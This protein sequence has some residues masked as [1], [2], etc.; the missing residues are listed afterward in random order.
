PIVLPTEFV[1]KYSR[2]DALEIR[3]AKGGGR[4][5]GHLGMIYRRI[6]NQGDYALVASGGHR[7]WVYL[8]QIGAHRPEIIDFA[9]GIMRVYRTDWQ[10][11]IDVFKKVLG[12]GSAPTSIRID[13][14]LYVIRAKSELAQEADDETRAA[15]AL[16]PA[17][18][19]AAQY[20]AMH[21]IAR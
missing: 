1:R 16:A 5:V 2:P 7:G 14:L 10:G 17:S 12:G 8:P 19:R 20:A 11:A 6:A 21:R 15:L 3:S 4:V 18:R 13:S 9:A